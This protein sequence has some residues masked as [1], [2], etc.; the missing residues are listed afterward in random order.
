MG[1]RWRGGTGRK[2]EAKRAGCT[3]RGKKSG[4]GCGRGKVARPGWGFLND[5]LGWVWRPSS[6]FLGSF[7]FS[8][9][10]TDRKADRHDKQD[11]LVLCAY[12]CAGTEL[13]GQRPPRPYQYCIKA[14]PAVA[15]NMCTRQMQQAR[16]AGQVGPSALSSL[17]IIAPSVPEQGGGCRWGGGGRGWTRHGGSL[18]SGESRLWHTGLQ[19]VT[20][21]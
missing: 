3:M 16:P 2:S 10:V 11:R 9:T 17:K 18:S 5:G 1:G 20:G 14:I 15:P 21:Q 7:S 19:V 8:L 4:P 13:D 6:G 12:A